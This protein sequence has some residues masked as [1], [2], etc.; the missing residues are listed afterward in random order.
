MERVW[1]EQSI[2]KLR[3]GLSCWVV[4]LRELA[5][6]HVGGDFPLRAQAESYESGVS[7]NPRNGCRLDHQQNADTAHRNLEM[8]VPGR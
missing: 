6:G 3:A 8:L 1:S 7:E 2:S 4:T 5:A